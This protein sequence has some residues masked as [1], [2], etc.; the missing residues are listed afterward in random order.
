MTTP[1]TRTLACELAVLEWFNTARVIQGHDYGAGQR[2]GELRTRRFD[3]A[4]RRLA[5]EHFLAAHGL[6]VDDARPADGLLPADELHAAAERLLRPR[7]ARIEREAYRR[8]TPASR[9]AATALLVTLAH[10]RRAHER[11]DEL[12]AELDKLREEHAE[13]RRS[14]D[15]SD[16]RTPAELDA[17]LARRTRA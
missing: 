2:A 5:D 17:E 7:L 8:D 16:W 15:P 4:V 3:P 12:E 11:A 10:F 1:A 9:R 14:A 6:P 13:E